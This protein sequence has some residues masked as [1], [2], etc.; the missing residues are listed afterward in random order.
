MIAS[1][2]QDFQTICSVFTQ[3]T[4]S[5]YSK[6]VFLKI[7]FHRHTLLFMLKFLYTVRAPYKKA[8][9]SL[10]MQPSTRPCESK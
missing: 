6:E 7:N 4:A 5:Y 10:V 2:L 9:P 3:V 1:R 8:S